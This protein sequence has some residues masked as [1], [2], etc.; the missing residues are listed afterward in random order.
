MEQ[1]YVMT[2][3]FM[4]ENEGAIFSGGLEKEGVKMVL[5]ATSRATWKQV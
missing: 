1:V 2:A 5:Q 4:E 3:M